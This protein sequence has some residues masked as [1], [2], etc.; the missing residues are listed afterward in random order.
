M[1]ETISTG[2]ILPS[3]RMK[4]DASQQIKLLFEHMDRQIDLADR[5]AQLIL[6]A[7]TFVAATI[8]NVGQG[9]GVSLFDNSARIEARLVGFCTIVLI[10]SLLISVYHALLVARPRLSV[11]RQR[12]TLHY[13]GHIILWSEQ[14]YISRFMNQTTREMD[15]ALLAQIHSRAHIANRKFVGIR[16]SLNFLFV[17]FLA[18]AMVRLLIAFSV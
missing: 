4:A 13:A 14:E 6:V 3:S 16:W 11:D 10:V 17:A 1:N 12:R 2:E 8:V 18:W 9:A 15:E 7:N 5:K